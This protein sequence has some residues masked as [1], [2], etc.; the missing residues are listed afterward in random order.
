MLRIRALGV[1]PFAVQQTARLTLGNIRTPYHEIEVVGFVVKL[2]ELLIRLTYLDRDQITWPPVEATL[3]TKIC[4]A[5][6][7]LSLKSSRR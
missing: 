4:V 6:F 2:C 7:R 5:S 1:R 3:S